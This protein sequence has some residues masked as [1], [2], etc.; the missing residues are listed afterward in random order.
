MIALKSN[1]KYVHQLVVSTLP[2]QDAVAKTKNSNT[3]AIYT[4]MMH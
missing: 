2:G 1:G 4:G 3:M